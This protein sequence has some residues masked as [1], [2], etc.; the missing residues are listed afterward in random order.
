MIERGSDSSS[1]GGARGDHATA[2]RAG[3]GTEFDD[4]VGRADEIPLVLDHDHGIAVPGERGDHLAQ[5]GDVAGVQSD[6]RL[7]QHLKNAGGAGAHGGGELD[8]LPL[9]GRQRGAGTVE[10]EVAQADVE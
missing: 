4:P 5:P 9:A 8:P 3:A 6:R 2:L 1:P 7:V 10:R